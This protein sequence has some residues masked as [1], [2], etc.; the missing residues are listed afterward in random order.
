MACSLLS[1]DLSLL[2]W[3]D[4]WKDLE[5]VFF[6]FELNS[7]QCVYSS[8]ISQHT[9]FFGKI[10][11][12]SSILYLAVGYIGRLNSELPDFVDTIF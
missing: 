8:A 11:E 12:A 6:F 7:L 5:M 9:T 2:S 1:R 4:G 10:F 3:K